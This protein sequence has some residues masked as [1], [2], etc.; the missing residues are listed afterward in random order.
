MA[1]GQK[2][3]SSSFKD[4]HFTTTHWSLVLA[5]GSPESP[6]QKEALEMLCRMYWYPLYAYLRR[7]GYNTDEAEE[8]TQAFFAH[9]LEKE[10]FSKVA[11]K[12]AKFRSFLLIALKH[13]LIDKFHHIAAAKRGGEKKRLPFDFEAGEKRYTF[14]PSHNLSPEKIFERSWALTLLDETLNRLENE[15]ASMKK[16]QLFNALRNH[17]CGNIDTVSYRDIAAR[18]GMT[19][20]AVKVTVYRLRKRFREILRD[21]ISQT[22]DSPE[23]IEE[24]LQALRAALT[25]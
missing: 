12:P 18:L 9:I 11:P 14:E 2:K 21:E 6:R 24:E 4:A 20:A 13:F 7:D 25:G 3:G 15:L 19:E 8:H 17:L 23:H 22:V 10:F 5:A 16:Q 1:T